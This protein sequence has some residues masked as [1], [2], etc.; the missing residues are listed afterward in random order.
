VLSG[1]STVKIPPKKSQAAS[2]ASMARAVD[3][4]NVG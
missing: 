3:S 1:M 4:S 2:H